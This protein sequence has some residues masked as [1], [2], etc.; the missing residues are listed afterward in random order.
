ML[1]VSSR[2]GRW[3]P[4]VTMLLL[5]L[6]RGR[7]PLDTPAGVAGPTLMLVCWQPALNVRL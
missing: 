7:L 6:R 5:L 1:V 3:L 2:G 4:P